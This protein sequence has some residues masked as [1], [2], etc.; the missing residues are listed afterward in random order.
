MVKFL[1]LLFTTASLAMAGNE[2]TNR[3]W[4]NGPYSLSPP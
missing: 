3:I 2:S 4:L 1:S